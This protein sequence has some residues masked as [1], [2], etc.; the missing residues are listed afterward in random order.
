MSW[1]CDNPSLLDCGPGDWST[2]GDYSF[3]V[4]TGTATWPAAQEASQIMD[5][6]L[7][8]ISDSSM[9]S[10]VY[11]LLSSNTA[12]IGAFRP[13]GGS[14]VKDGWQWDDG[15]PWGTFNDWEPGQPGGDDG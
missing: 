8:A 11:S 5:G 14:N 12:W 7:A 13:P 2:L 3:L 6:T 15:T 4:S 1:G 10:F 9:K